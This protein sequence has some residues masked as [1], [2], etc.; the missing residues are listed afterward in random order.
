MSEEE[1]L[2][3]FTPLLLD[4]FHALWKMGVSWVGSPGNAYT[5]VGQKGKER[6]RALVEYSIITVL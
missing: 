6:G 3:S 2:D 5:R 1:A 4:A